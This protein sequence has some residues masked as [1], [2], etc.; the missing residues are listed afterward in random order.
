MAQNL[1]A[2]L[3]NRVETIATHFD[4]LATPASEESF[5]GM[6]VTKQSI[7]QQLD[8]L[9]VHQI[10]VDEAVRTV[11]RS[12]VQ[13]AGLE[14]SDFPAEVAQLAGCSTRGRFERAMLGDVDEPDE[15][16]DVLPKS[17]TSGTPTATRST[18]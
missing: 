14:Q 3:Q 10:P 7:E 4:E 6:A 5:S 1:T 11:V 9:V 2:D 12:A 17:S 18:R 8:L 15:W 13:N 16:I